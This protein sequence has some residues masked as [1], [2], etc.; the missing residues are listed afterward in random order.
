MA[1]KDLKI[2]VVNHKP[3]NVSD[4]GTTRV[5]NICQGLAR[6]GHEITYTAPPLSNSLAR[7]FFRKLA[8][9]YAG[10]FG[11]AAVDLF[12]CSLPRIQKSDV[13]I[14]QVEQIW[15]SL[16]STFQAQIR[17]IPCVFDA[18]NVESD[19]AAQLSDFGY[20]P[21]PWL[22]YVAYLE[23][24]AAQAASHVVTTSELDKESLAKLAN[25]PEKKITVIPNG[26]DLKKYHPYPVYCPPGNDKY[27]A[28]VGRYSYPPNRIAIDY[29]V[30]ELAPQVWKKHPRTFFWIVSRDYP[31]N[32][33]KDPRIKILRQEDD[34]GP[35]RYSDIC[36]APLSVGGGTRIK[37]FNY[38]A[39]GKP[40]VATPIAAEGIP[41]QDIILSVLDYFPE[42]VNDALDR[43]LSG[44]SFRARRFTEEECSW[45]KSVDKFEQLYEKIL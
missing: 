27:L 2:S 45:E 15:S 17:N 4:G 24:H 29:I 13:D 14:I 18:H 37:I 9:K 23:I 19:L 6:R 40:V 22:I 1:C 25:I 26:T 20:G 11:S 36:L 21:M 32:T 12:A 8:T 34:S 38:L 35:I 5:H 7:R 33:Q 41:T 10:E 28:F 43:D 3:L 16:W 42:T 39:C 44:L 31:C 30:R